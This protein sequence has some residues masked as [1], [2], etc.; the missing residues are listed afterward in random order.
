MS[1]ENI[2]QPCWNIFACQ[3]ATILAKRGLRI[4]HLDNRR[5]IGIHPQVV[6]RLKDSMQKPTSFPVLNPDDLRQVEEVLQFTTEERLHL[7][8]AILA[9]AIEEELM[10]HLYDDDALLAAQQIFPTLV[11][12]L[13]KYS[14]T[15]TG[16]GS[17][18]LRHTEEN[19]EG[20]MSD[21]DRI[22]MA[23]STAL[24]TLDRA[25]KGL[26]LDNIETH[27]ERIS[28]VRQTCDSFKQALTELLEVDQDI[29]QTEAWKIWEEEAQKG[30]KQAKV[31]LQDLL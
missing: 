6:R 12:A 2:S 8:A 14:Y 28:K 27:S 4:G 10:K 11:K 25:T 18:L 26:Y 21:A 3:L 29:Q 23:L 31:L 9:T 17:F 15:E 13:E 5:S 24:H 30:L 20:H 7:R 1:D 16:L 22:D 19:Q